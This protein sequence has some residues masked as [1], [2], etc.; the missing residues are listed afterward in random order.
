MYQPPHFQETRPDVL[1]GLIRAHPL[2]LLVSSGPEGP[3]ADAIPF[4]ID[5]DVGP[6]GRLRAHLAR[7]NPQWRL[8]ADNPAS[9]VLIVFQGTDAYVTPS[10]YE[11]KR[12]TGK[13]VP[14]W[15]YAIVQVRGT[16]KVIDDQDWLARQIADLTASQEGT[17]EA[18]WAVTDA[19][20]PFIQSQIKGIIG[21]E[22]EI[23]EI[24]GKWKVSQNRP[25][26]DRAGVA[27]GLESET[28]NSS[29]MVNLVRSYGGLNGD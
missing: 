3:V 4:L 28:A 17:R 16:A 1:H 8:I 21:L 25:V 22:I 2:G 27:H 11:T 15:N 29:D 12:E 9:T 20:A 10:W 7:A 23:A 24:H 19:P 5:A 18:P 6:N 26:A 14:T 13:V